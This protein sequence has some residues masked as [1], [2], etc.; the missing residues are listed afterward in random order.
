M[1][2]TAMNPLLIL[3]FFKGITNAQKHSIIATNQHREKEVKSIVYQMVREKEVFGFNWDQAAGRAAKE[4]VICQREGVAIF[5]A[6]DVDNFPSILL[7]ISDPPVVL[8]G[9]GVWNNKKVPL[10][11]IGSRKMT[12]YGKHQCRHF[13]EDLSQFPINIISGLAMGIDTV[14]HQT[15]VDCGASTQ[16]FLAGGLGHISPKR[17][18]LLA[19]Q[20][21]DSGGGYFTEQPFHVA[22]LPQYYPV[23]NRLI[24]GASLATLVLEAEKKSGAMITAN[25][26]FNYGREVYALP[27]ALFQPMSKG[28]NKLIAD[29][30]ASIVL[31]PASF[32]SNFY[33]LWSNNRGEI[34]LSKSLEGELIQHFPHGRKVHSAYLKRFFK[35]SNSQLFKSLHVLLEL[36]VIQRIG[37]HTFAR[38][39]AD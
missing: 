17:N 28:P 7:E 33:P 32:A 10:S 1:L 18:T 6:N 26:A 24:A 15:A 25:Q 30:I 12:N 39:T 21:I 37:P 38:K 2:I 22:S 35:V 27:G 19:Q 20:I 3:H 14:A 23:R 11:V 9:R 31:D 13:V 29:Q 34:D 5:Y 8:F 36:G 16:A 4:Q